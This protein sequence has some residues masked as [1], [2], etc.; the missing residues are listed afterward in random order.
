M[1]IQKTATVG[2]RLV[3]LSAFV[4]LSQF[5]QSQPYI[6]LCNMMNLRF[7]GENHK[8]LLT[9][10]KNFRNVLSPAQKRLL[11]SRRRLRGSSFTSWIGRSAHT[12][13]N[14]LLCTQA[15]TQCVLHGMAELLHQI[16][17][18]DLIGLGQVS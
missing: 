12:V 8:N 14:T 7:F 17:Y 11:R 13:W 3:L 10:T 4:H 18:T 9:F 15:S 16:K 6:K 1:A 2:N 5:H